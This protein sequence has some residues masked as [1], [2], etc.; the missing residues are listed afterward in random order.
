MTRKKREKKTAVIIKGN[1]KYLKYHKKESRKFY[2]DIG[3]FLKSKGYRV[4]YNAGKSYTTPP[5]ADL[6][7]GHSRGAGRL[8]FAPDYTKTIAF[9]TPRDRR[10]SFKVINHPEDDRTMAEFR[11]A[12]NGTRGLKPGREHYIFTDEMRQ[13]LEKIAGSWGYGIH[14]NDEVGDFAWEVFKTLGIADE[15]RPYKHGIHKEIDPKVFHRRYPSLIRK[16]LREKEPEIVQKERIKD[17]W[18]ALQE[19]DVTLIR[20][21]GS[22]VKEA[23]GI[24]PTELA[25]KYASWIRDA[26]SDIAEQSMISELN[27]IATTQFSIAARQ[28]DPLPIKLDK[29]EQTA[30]SLDG[31]M[32]KLKYLSGDETYGRLAS[33][34]LKTLENVTKKDA[35]MTRSTTVRLP[36]QEPKLVTRKWKKN[37][38]GKEKLF[39]PKNVGGR[40]NINAKEGEFLV[41]ERRISSNQRNPLV[42]SHE[43]AHSVDFSKRHGY[44]PRSLDPAKKMD[45]KAQKGVV[46]IAKGLDRQY[47]SDMAKLTKSERFGRTLLGRKLG[48]KTKRVRNDSDLEAVGKFQRLVGAKRKRD[49]LQNEVQAN[50]RTLDAYEPWSKRE[51]LKKMKPRERR[52]VAE[53]LSHHTTY[54]EEG[55]GEGI[56]KQ[57][58]ATG[59]AKKV[60]KIQDLERR[61]QDR[62]LGK[63]LTKKEGKRYREKMNRLRALGDRGVQRSNNPFRRKGLWKGMSRDDRMDYIW[64]I[65][66]NAKRIESDFGR[67]AAK[68]Y[69]SETMRKLRSMM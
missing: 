28:K 10:D 47:D 68:L 35:G 22:L 40:A 57:Q 69:R 3:S 34:K 59:Y 62:H 29:R 21:D 39:R 32:K 19:S 52:N 27:K 16:C 36:E 15:N 9:G 8:R 14:D 66:K 37:K 33:E 23:E 50:R 46:T 48:V 12:G 1:P 4:K 17:V 13:E 44:D 30:F 11:K 56:R 51:S 67:D 41:A 55:G 63:D 26:V 53:L 58:E 54:L 60:D 42:L 43:A 20:H 64:Q 38:E 18:K 31:Y 61:I 24:S 2:R 45:A 7:I 25:R 65:K 5:D 49:R 6:W